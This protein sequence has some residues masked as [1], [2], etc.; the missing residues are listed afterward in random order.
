MENPTKDFF[1]LSPGKEVRLKYAY[2]IVC[3]KVVKDKKSGEI[4]EIQCRYKIDTKSGESEDDKIHRTIHWISEKNAVKAE[5]RLYYQLFTKVN[6]LD[7]EEG[8]EFTDYINP[9]S[10]KIVEAYVEPHLQKAAKGTRYQFERKGF[11]N[12]DPIDSKKNALVFNQTIPLRDS[13]PK[14]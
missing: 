2:V 1:R 12:I 11:F 7:T 3:D 5:V 14:K 8:K 6:P 10:L 13:K 9:D 4:K